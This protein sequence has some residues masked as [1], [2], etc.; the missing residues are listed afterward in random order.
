MLYL[1]RTLKISPKLLL[2][3]LAFAVTTGSTLSPI[4]NLQNLLVAINGNLA[5]PFLVFLRYLFLPTAR[6]PS[7]G[8]SSAPV[9]LRNQFRHRPLQICQEQVRDPGL[10]HLARISH[11]LAACIDLGKDR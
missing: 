9:I 3:T 6:Q 5:N 10:A 1:S 7:A 2:L 4:G 11:S 8:L